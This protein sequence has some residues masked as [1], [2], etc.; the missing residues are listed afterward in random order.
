[1]ESVPDKRK[2]TRRGV[3]NDLRGC[4]RATDVRVVGAVRVEADAS[5]VAARSARTSEAS[6]VSDETFVSERDV[7]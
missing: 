4:T 2:G 3:N 1:V 6:V 7:Q 5:A